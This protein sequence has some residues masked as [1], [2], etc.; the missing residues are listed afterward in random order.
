MSILFWIVF[1]I[2]L[3]KVIWNFGVPYALLWKP[4]DTKTGKRGGIS[5]FLEIEIFF[6]ILAIGLSW[7]SRGD[8]WINNPLTVLGFGGGGILVSYLHFFVGGMITNWVVTRK[9]RSHPS[10]IE[11]EPKGKAQ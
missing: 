9:Q 1:G 7:F 6:L 11:D 3:L 8:S 10:D 4:I 5:L 2:S